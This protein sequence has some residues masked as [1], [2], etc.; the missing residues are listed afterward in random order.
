MWHTYGAIC[1]WLWTKLAKLV[2]GVCMLSS[3]LPFLAA[4]LGEHCNSEQTSPSKWLCYC[5][6]GGNIILTGLLASPLTP[7][8]SR[9]IWIVT[10][11]FWR[12]SLCV[13]VVVEDVGYVSLSSRLFWTWGRWHSRVSQDHYFRSDPDPSQFHPFNHAPFHRD[14]TTSFR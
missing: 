5:D 3:V 6:Q 13:V 4:L 1:S 10:P 2:R 12:A 11:L 7:D 14:Q 9:L 8:A